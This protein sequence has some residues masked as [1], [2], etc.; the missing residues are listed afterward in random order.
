MAVQACFDTDCNGATVGSILG[1][2]GGTKT[3]SA[4]WKDAIRNK[5]QT[6]IFGVGE[7]NVDDVVA[8]TVSHLEK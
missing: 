6:S 7:V 1:M 5:L 4:V 8:T 2:R 3:I